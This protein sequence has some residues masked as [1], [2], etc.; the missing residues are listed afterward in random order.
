MKPA[1]KTRDECVRSVR[2]ELSLRMSVYPRRVAERKM[3]R[4]KADHEI[5]CMERILEILSE[6]LPPEPKQ[7]GMFDENNTN[8]TQS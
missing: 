6:G 5:A 3:T 1:R 4:E 8:T 7:L 2:R